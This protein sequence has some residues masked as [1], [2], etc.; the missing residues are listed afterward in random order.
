[1]RAQDVRLRTLEYFHNF[2]IKLFNIYYHRKS[3][4]R[5]IL[6]SIYKPNDNFLDILADI[7]ASLVEKSAPIILMVPLQSS[8]ILRLTSG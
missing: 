2:T 5:Y 7:T 6:A 4:R 3:R 1:M 8:L